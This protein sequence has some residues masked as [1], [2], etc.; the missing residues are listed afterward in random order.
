MSSHVL[1]P[2]NVLSDT[3]WFTITKG[4]CSLSSNSHSL[5]IFVET[6]DFPNCLSTG[7][8]RDDSLSGSFVNEWSFP[9]K[10]FT[11]GRSCGRCYKGQCRQIPRFSSLR[12]LRRRRRSLGSAPGSRRPDVAAEQ[13]KNSDGGRYKVV[14]R[15]MPDLFRAQNTMTRDGRGLMYNTITVLNILARLASVTISV[16]LGMMLLLLI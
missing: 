7:C 4:H 6:H 12:R 10:R 3:A 9:V 13:N 1:R 5:K 8:R 2:E 16:W 11:M 15:R 14:Q